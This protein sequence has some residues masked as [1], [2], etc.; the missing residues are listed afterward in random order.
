MVNHLCVLILVLRG[1]PAAA[2]DRSLDVHPFNLEVKRPM[3]LV[4]YRHGFVVQFR[5][6][7]R[8]SGLR[9]GKVARHRFGH[10]RILDEVG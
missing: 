1:T 6:V 3:M 4:Q 5:P 8:V 10:A 2:L 9:A 7:G